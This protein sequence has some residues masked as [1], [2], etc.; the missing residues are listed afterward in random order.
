MG[1]VGFVSIMP[2][3]HVLHVCASFLCIGLCFVLCCVV[4]IMFMIKC[5]LDVFVCLF[6]F[7]GIQSL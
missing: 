4:H 5:L 3:L 1:F 6:G 7:Y 2:F